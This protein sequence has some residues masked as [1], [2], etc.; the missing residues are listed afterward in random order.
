MRPST[1]TKGQDGLKTKTPP[2][3]AG[4]CS[5]DSAL[6]RPPGSLGR[7]RGGCQRLHQQH[8]LDGIQPG[9]IV[10]RA[11]LVDDAAPRSRIAQPGDVALNVNQAALQFGKVL[12][13]DLLRN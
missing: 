11:D 4:H 5:G 7:R 6:L 12:A 2:P 3:P 13:V 10:R 9:V 8:R 1:E